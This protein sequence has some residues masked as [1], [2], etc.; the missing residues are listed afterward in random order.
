MKNEQEQPEKTGTQLE[1]D[2]KLEISNP[3]KNSDVKPGKEKNIKARKKTEESS[4]LGEALP[5]KAD[6]SNMNG[7]ASLPHDQADLQKP[8][9]E[10]HENHASLSKS[11]LQKIGIGLAGIIAG[12]LLAYL[13]LIIPLQTQLASI[14]EANFNGNSSTN[15]MKSDLSTT[16]LKQEEMQTRYQEVTTQLES[17]NQYIFLL[18]IKEQISYTRLMVE[19]K[20]GLEARHALSEI[21][22][23]FEHLKPLV[24]KKDALAAVKIEEFIKVA[25]QHLASDPESVKTDLGEI[26]DL[27]GQIETTLFQ[28]EK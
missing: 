20:N 21:Q 7:D 9:E 23:R 14:T 13:L 24:V 15:I 10:F 11:R 26:S 25:I 2:E 8:A 27:L 5:E 4:V 1:A 3:G 12:F 28:P 6:S 19:Q 18:R 16:K 22:G 17:A